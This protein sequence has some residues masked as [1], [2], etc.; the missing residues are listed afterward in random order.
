MF[1]VRHY[2]TIISVCSINC[3]FPCP[4]V[5]KLRNRCIQSKAVYR[6]MFVEVYMQCQLQTVQF[7]WTRLHYTRN[8]CHFVKPRDLLSCSQETY[9]EVQ[10]QSPYTHTHTHTHIHT[11]KRTNTETQKHTN[12]RTNTQTHKHTNT[13]THKHRNTQKHK[14][15]LLFL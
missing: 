5:W 15:T 11:H 3:C 4:H 10:S 1:H 2:Q 8:S 14:H 13:E 6:H 7:H 9:F 12:T